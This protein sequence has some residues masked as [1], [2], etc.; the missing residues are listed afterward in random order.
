MLVTHEL[1][2]LHYLDK[3]VNTL[4]ENT[5]KIYNTIF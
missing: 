4:V 5:V 3:K 1:P 2:I